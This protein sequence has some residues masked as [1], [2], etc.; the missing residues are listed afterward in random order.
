ME[1]WEKESSREKTGAEV[2][3]E[4][5]FRSQIAPVVKIV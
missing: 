4:S 5:R 1:Q 2:K 3:E